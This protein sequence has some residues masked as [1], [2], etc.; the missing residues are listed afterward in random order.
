MSGNNLLFPLELVFFV[1]IAIIIVKLKDKYPNLMF[2][3]KNVEVYL[4]P[5]ESEH[6]DLI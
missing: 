5:T 4:P 1:S 6:K 2:P 3:P